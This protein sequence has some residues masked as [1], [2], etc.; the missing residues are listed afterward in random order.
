MAQST[1][2]AGF[3]SIYAKSSFLRTASITITG[4]LTNVD[5]VKNLLLPYVSSTNIGTTILEVVNNGGGHATFIISN[6]AD[7]ADALQLSYYLS[8]K[9]RVFHYNNGNW[10]VKE[11]VGT[12]V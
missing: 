10:T 7:Y 3:E 11:F 9:L 6:S 2:K 1:I 8:G 5:N 12:T 4:S